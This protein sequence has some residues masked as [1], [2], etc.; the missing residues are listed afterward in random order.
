MGEIR[1]WNPERAGSLQERRQRALDSTRE[2][3]W[4]DGRERR[5]VALHQQEER[6]GAIDGHP[7]KVQ[8]RWTEPVGG[9]QQPALHFGHEALH[10]PLHI[11][12]TKDGVEA[13]VRRRPELRDGTV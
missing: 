7:P 6:R 2:V 10:A 11:L 4:C 1:G 8:N 9:G 12:G 13:A 3:R 5:A